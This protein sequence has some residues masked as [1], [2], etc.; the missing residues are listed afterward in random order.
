MFGIACVLLSHGAERGQKS[1]ASKGSHAK[2]AESAAVIAETP[3]TTRTETERGIRTERATQT[4]GEAMNHHL[5]VI[6]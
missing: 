5:K 6:P 1:D 3:E 2:T 4:P